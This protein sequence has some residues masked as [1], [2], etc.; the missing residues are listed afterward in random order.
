MGDGLGPQVALEWCRVERTAARDAAARL[1]TAYFSALTSHPV[2]LR[3]FAAA[4]MVGDGGVPKSMQ[5][6]ACHIIHH[7]RCCFLHVQPHAFIL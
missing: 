4:A 5:H 3:G 6:A 1:L 2:G 7:V